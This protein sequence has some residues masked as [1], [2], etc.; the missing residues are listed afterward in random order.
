M[1]YHKNKQLE[2]DALEDFC[3]WA[4]GMIKT[5]DRPDYPKTPHDFVERL[6]RNPKTGRFMGKT[7]G[8]DWHYD[9]DTI[10]FAPDDYP[11]G[12]CMVIKAANTD[13]IVDED[14]GYH[15]LKLSDL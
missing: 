7:Y 12:E 1:G 10:V 5:F 8:I 9:K 4:Q 6:Y 11:Y 14:V 13:A 15:G 2:Q 3:W